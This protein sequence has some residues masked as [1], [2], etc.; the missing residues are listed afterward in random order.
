LAVTVVL[1]SPGRALVT[2]ISFGLP[3][4]PSTGTGPAPASAG[5]TT[6]LGINRIDERKDLKA[7]AAMEVGSALTTT[8]GPRDERGRRGIS[9]STGTR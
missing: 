3:R 7:S 6:W 8:C 2:M 9:A 5:C 1:P 4:S